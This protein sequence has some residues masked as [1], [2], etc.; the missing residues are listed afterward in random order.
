L[1][2]YALALAIDW[3]PG[4]TWLGSSWEFATAHSFPSR[5]T[6]A[7]HIRVPWNRPPASPPVEGAATKNV[8]KSAAVGKPEQLLGAVCACALRAGVTTP[9][10]ANAITA[11]VN[12]FI[13]I[14]PYWEYADYASQGDY[15]SGLSRLR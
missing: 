6:T 3:L 5:F 9:M 4:H 2:V 11:L 10:A 14:S 13:E 12:L 8:F 7:T 15:I 1:A